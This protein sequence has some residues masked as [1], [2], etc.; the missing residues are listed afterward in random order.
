MRITSS[1]DKGITVAFTYD[2][3]SAVHDDLGDIMASR[4]SVAG[5]RL[6]RV[7]E[8]ALDHKPSKNLKT[9]G[10]YPSKRPT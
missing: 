3:A 1:N 8:V 5:D 2:E 6:H 9:R 4:I 7:L 10:R